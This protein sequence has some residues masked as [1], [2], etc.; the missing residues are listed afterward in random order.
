[1]RGN[2]HTDSMRAVNPDQPKSPGPTGLPPGRLWPRIRIMKA[3]GV[4]AKTWTLWVRMGL[5]VTTL[6]TN[7]DWAYT[8]DVLA[9]G[10]KWDAKFHQ[11]A[12]ALKYRRPDRKKKEN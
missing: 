2:E 3:M 11:Q 10:R 4:D 6:G 8:D 7:R 5:Y 1:M 12:Q 9:L